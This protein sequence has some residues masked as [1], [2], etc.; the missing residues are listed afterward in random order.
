MYSQIGDCHGIP[1][2][3]AKGTKDSFHIMVRIY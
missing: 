3:Y 1:K 2:V